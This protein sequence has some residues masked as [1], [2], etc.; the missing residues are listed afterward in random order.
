VGVAERQ[1]LAPAAP[2]SDDIGAPLF[3]GVHRFF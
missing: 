2:L 1:P 3:V